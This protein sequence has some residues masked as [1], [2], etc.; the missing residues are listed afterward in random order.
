MSL[1][2]LGL[3]T[4]TPDQV[5]WNAREHLDLRQQVYKWH[6]ERD[7]IPLQTQY[8]YAMGVATMAMAHNFA[9]EFDL[10]LPY[11]KKSLELYDSFPMYRNWKTVPY[12]AV[13]HAGWALWSLG[14]N[15][16]AEGVLLKAV[17]AD[18][19]RGAPGS[20]G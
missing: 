2:A 17:N 5:L 7:E 6:T 12:F 11:A 16:E 20:Y 18:K 19:E 13:A 14:R 8:D 15:E 4:S 10:A 9:G 1:A 3:H